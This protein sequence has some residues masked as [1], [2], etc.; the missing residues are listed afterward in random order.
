M[1]CWLVLLMCLMLSYSVPVYSKDISAKVEHYVKEAIKIRQKS[2]KKEDE[3]F[4]EKQRLEAEYKRLKEENKLL[5]KEV[6][7]LKS[8][9]S[10]HQHALK[11]IKDEICKIRQIE[12]QIYPFILKTY[13]RLN[14]FIKQ[15]TPF[16][17]QERTKRLV[18]L[19]K[20]IYDPEVSIAEK[21]R[22]LMDAIFIEADYGNTIEVYQGRIK[23]NRS[24]IYANIFRL[25][26]VSLFFQSLDGKLSGYYDPGSGWRL[27]PSRYNKP[28]RTA[29]EIA[30]RRRPAEIVDLPIGRI[31]K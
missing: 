14:S 31:K 12:E 30:Q 13:E 21:F 3:W 17:L 16:L 15:D 5:S 9:I 6:S 19:K 20:V 10:L 28:I 23:L 2:Q 22:R 26:R 1:S 18:S 7:E 4:K 8:K 11:E 29:I 25:G 24:F 27:L